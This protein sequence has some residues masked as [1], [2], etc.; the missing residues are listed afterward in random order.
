MGKDVS[1]EALGDAKILASRISPYDY[2]TLKMYWEMKSYALIA[3]MRSIDHWPL[4]EAEPTT[5]STSMGLH[6]ESAH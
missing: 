4:V 6:S 2:G 5:Q 1:K 3:Y